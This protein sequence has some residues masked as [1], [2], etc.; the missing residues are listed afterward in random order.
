MKKIVVYRKF[1]V[2]SIG[3]CCVLFLLAG[4]AVSAG[5][6]GENTVPFNG[7]QMRIGIPLGSHLLDPH[8]IQSSSDRTIVSALFEGLYVYD[9]ETGNAA[10]GLAQELTVN[11]DETVYTCTLR[12]AEWS[13][14][15]AITAKTVVE[16]WY[17]LLDPELQA[18]FSWLAA[19]VIRG[20]A[21]YVS[22]TGEKN[23]VGIKAVE[24]FV[25]EIRL[26]QPVPYIKEILAHPA[27]S[28]VPIHKIAEYPDDWTNSAHF[29]C[30]GPFLLHRYTSGNT[31]ICR[32]NPTYW[33]K[34]QVAL[35]QIQFLMYE[36]ETKA[37]QE[38]LEGRLDWNTAL[39]GFSAEAEKSEDYHKHPM[40]SSLFILINTKNE[41]FISTGAREALAA[42]ID[43]KTV[44]SPRNKAGFIPA[45][46]LIPSAGL[47]KEYA[48]ISMD[49]E[50][51]GSTAE[52]M[53]EG[54]LEQAGTTATILFYADPVFRSLGKNLVKQWDKEFSLSIE[55][56]EVGTS[57]Y[58]QRLSKG[59][60]DAVLVGWVA[61]CNEPGMLLEMFTADGGGP[62]VGFRNDRYDSL[63][64]AANKAHSEEKRYELLEDAEELLLDEY[65][66]VPLFHYCSQ[67]MIDIDRR[68]GW[69][70]NPLDVHPL[71][72]VTSEPNSKNDYF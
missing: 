69:Y 72:K 3:I 52:E 59:Q 30:N 1:G 31:L 66:V 61:E 55:T 43:R 36:D 44:L 42:G 60:F 70:H 64:E 67:N 32:K 39:S 48:S 10:P 47:Y 19:R 54:S 50:N 41:P 25:V 24:K 58:T 68:Q 29:V 71:K 49:L 40:L 63:I 23:D 27:F 33:D 4:G 2:V 26:K 65:V 16:S 11:D 35:D 20:A 13:D 12:Q 14:G 38:Y 22:G 5:G 57:E 37:V 51:N 9:P 56:E 21:D 45:S 28:L 15:T 8:L 6:Q 53:G 34:E 7:K 62:M 46:T 17:R 18:P